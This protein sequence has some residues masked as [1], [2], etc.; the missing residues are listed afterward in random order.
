MGCFVCPAKPHFH[1][2]TALQTISIVRCS[3]PHPINDNQ[4]ADWR[5]R[6]RELEAEL[7]RLRNGMSTM[8]TDIDSGQVL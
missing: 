5:R 2:T 4:Q 7:A 3:T 1:S 6:V 8:Q